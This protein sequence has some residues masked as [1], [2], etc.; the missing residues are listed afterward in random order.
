M[1]FAL[2]P[3]IVAGLG[4]WLVTRWRP[5]DPAWWLPVRVAGALL[6]V[7]GAVVLLHA[8]WRFVREG[9]GTPAPVA[10]TERLVVGGLYRHIRNPMYVAVVACILGQALLLSSPALL[11]YAAIAGGGM[12][13]FARWYEEPHLAAR[14]GG[15][16]RR[17]R[18]S[19]PG[20]WPRLRP[21]QG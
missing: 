21:W 10:P 4:P 20:W 13:A 16:Y 15:Q 2:A 11:V 19:V 9:A 17:Y 1:F 18:E 7:A 5:G 6:L 3:G 12:A 14:Y 8:F